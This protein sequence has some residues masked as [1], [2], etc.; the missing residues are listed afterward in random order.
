[1]K[2]YTSVT[3]DL[4]RPR[5]FSGNGLSSGERGIVLGGMR[6]YKAIWDGAQSLGPKARRRFG[7][8]R[9]KGRHVVPREFVIRDVLIRVP[10]ASTRA[11]A[12]IQD[13]PGL[14]GRVDSSCAD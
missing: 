12:S 11:Q 14:W 2:R 8:R 9:A 7:R 13:A 3:G 1:M 10:P 5:A 4:G 6:G